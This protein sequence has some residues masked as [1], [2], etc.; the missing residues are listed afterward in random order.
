MNQSV[1]LDKLLVL[2][3]IQFCFSLPVMDKQHP[4]GHYSLTNYVQTTCI[5][6][7]GTTITLMP[8]LKLITKNVCTFSNQQQVK[9]HMHACYRSVVL[10]LSL[11]VTTLEYVWYQCLLT[12][13]LPNVL[14]VLTSLAS[15]ITDRRN[16]ILQYLF[17]TVECSP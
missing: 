5:P 8:S 17:H 3:I 4:Y 12:H 1:S 15:N 16:N 10:K 6:M 11:R 7:I 14:F 13:P 2:D 9:I